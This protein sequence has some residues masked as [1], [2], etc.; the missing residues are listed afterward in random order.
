MKQ[1]VGKL[2]PLK[3]GMVVTIYQDPYT[4]IKKEGT[5]TLVKLLDPHI[6]EQGGK[7]LQRWDVRFEGDRKIFI[8]NILA[9]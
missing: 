9:D 2:Y 1:N 6:G 4:R 8:R 5:A 7:L 3:K